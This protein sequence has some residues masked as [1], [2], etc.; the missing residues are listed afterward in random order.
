VAPGGFLFRGQ[1]PRQKLIQVRGN[2]TAVV[3]TGL[4]IRQQKQ[5]GIDLIY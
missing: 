5:L 4:K 2:P 3:G 1:V